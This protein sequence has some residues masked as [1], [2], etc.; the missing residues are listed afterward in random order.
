[1]IRSNHD[2]NNSSSTPFTIAYIAFKMFNMTSNP[3]NQ[4]QEIPCQKKGKIKK[5]KVTNSRVTNLHS[6]QT[7]IFKIKATRHTKVHDGGVFTQMLIWQYIQKKMGIAR[8]FSKWQ[9]SLT[10]CVIRFL[11]Y[12]DR[13]CTLVFLAASHTR[14]I[15]PPSTRP[16]IDLYR[17]TYRSSATKSTISSPLQ[18]KKC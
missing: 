12:A 15:R 1:M 3:Y 4:K 2:C 14:S 13:S 8:H 17:R 10:R 9:G 11:N 6:H 7:E 18:G 16:F 5:K